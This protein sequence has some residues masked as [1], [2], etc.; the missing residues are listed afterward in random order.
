MRGTKKKQATRVAAPARQR[1]K[2]TQRRGD[3]RR[4]RLLRAAH[5]LLERKRVSDLTYAAVCAEARV[6]TGSARFFYPD[7]DS[8]LHALLR[9]LGEKHD[10]ALMR[11]LRPSDVATW[12]TLLDCLIERSARFQ[13][14]NRVFADLSIGGMTTPDLKHMDREADRP[15]AMYVLAALEEHFALPR[16]PDRERV[17]YLLVEIVDL[18]FMLS[19]REAGAITPVWLEHAKV[20]AG[21]LFSQHFG[22]PEAR[23]SFPTPT[24]GEKGPSRT[25]AAPDTGTDG[26]A[27]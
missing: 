15:R 2:S 18:V 22:D 26:E 17:A 4:E 11:P 6:P 9:D 19:M 12:R 5:T 24:T 8:M 10:A 7:L 21:A 23:P 16:V 14:A 27:V 25:P 1:L 3:E 20:A 13:R